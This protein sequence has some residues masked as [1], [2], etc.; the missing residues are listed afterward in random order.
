MPEA[1]AGT[2]LARRRSVLGALGARSPSD[3]GV[4]E[5][6]EGKARSTEEKQNMLGRYLGSVDDLVEDLRER[7][8]FGAVF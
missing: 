8:P 5:E 6:G 7:M 4:G 2:G 1:P 3:A